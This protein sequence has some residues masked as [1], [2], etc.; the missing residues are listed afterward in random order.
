VDYAALKRDGLP[1]LEAYLRSLEAVDTTAYATWTR[2]EQLAFWLNAYNAYMW[3][4]VA[5]NHP[6]KSV[7]DI[8]KVAFSAFKRPF[9]PLAALERR[10]L[11]LDDIEHQIV[12]KRFS[13]P[14][15]HFALVCAARS[16]PALRGEAYRAADLDRQLDEDG[17]AFLAD[18]AR[19]QFDPKTRTLRLSEIFKWFRGD[20]EAAAGNLLAFVARYVV[21]ATAAAL[22]A[23]GVALEFLPYDWSLNGK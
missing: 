6:L 1:A 7:R 9:I 10:V 2:H 5:E 14:R 8:G 19:N 13:E 4:V 16:C 3:K 22:K 20:F 15:I 18:S 17:R 12:R 21:A 23:P 11:S